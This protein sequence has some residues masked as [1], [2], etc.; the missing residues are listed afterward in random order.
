MIVYHWKAIMYGIS[1]A[2][3]EIVWMMNESRRR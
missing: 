2:S 1:V 3:K